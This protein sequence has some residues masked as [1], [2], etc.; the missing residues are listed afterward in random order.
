MDIYE[1]LEN[2]ENDMMTIL[3]AA[4]SFIS[5]AEPMIRFGM[6]QNWTNNDLRYLLQ[7]L[8]DACWGECGEP[9]VADALTLVRELE[10]EDAP[11]DR[12]VFLTI[13]TLAEKLSD[14]GESEDSRALAKLILSAL[15][16][17]PKVTH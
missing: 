7:G 4:K 14:L 5:E 8:T 13:Q 10:F 6:W 9:L 3:G 15:S 16:A 17:F 1:Q 11:Q 12:A 2:L